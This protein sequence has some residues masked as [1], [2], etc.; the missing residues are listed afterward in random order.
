M[1]HNDVNQWLNDKK[2]SDT[3]RYDNRNSAKRMDI[4][5]DRARNVLYRRE[6]LQ[7]GSRMAD[8]VSHSEGDKQVVKLWWAA[9]THVLGR[10]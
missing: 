2:N 9:Q 6:L 10:W 5:E 1:R 8:A 3:F 4:V 7:A